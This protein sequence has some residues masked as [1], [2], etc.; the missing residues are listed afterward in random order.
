MYRRGCLSQRAYSYRLVVKA[1]TA[2]YL[3]GLRH[4][5][6][7]SRRRVSNR[8]ED[9]LAGGAHRYPAHSEPSTGR[10]AA[11]FQLNGNAAPDV[12]YLH[13]C[14]TQ[15]EFGADFWDGVLYLPLEVNFHFDRDAPT[16]L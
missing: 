2:I 12:K 1:A 8:R 7:Y 13:T 9:G 16:G 11:V 15:N 4:K 3:P 5:R 6:Y 14:L 10:F